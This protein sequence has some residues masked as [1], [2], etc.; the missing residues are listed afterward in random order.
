MLVW[1][2]M[3]VRS[4]NPSYAS[5]DQRV[6]IVQGEVVKKLASYLE[7]GHGIPGKYISIK[8]PTK[9]GGKK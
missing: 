1:A 3:H 6:G 4:R 9:K 8:E 5:A 2:G 7:S